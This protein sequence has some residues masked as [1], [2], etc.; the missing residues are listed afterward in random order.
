VFKA[1][2]R[3]PEGLAVHPGQPVEVRPQ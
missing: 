3:A 2:A 1:E